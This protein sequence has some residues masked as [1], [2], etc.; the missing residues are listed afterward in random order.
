MF[1]GIV[2]VSQA[3]AKN[4]GGGGGGGGGADFISL[5]SAASGLIFR[6][7]VLQNTLHLEF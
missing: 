6:P 4:L 7:K 1:D 3:L 2:M 5:F